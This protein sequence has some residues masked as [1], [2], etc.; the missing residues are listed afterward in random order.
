VP[1]TSDDS[2]TTARDGESSSQ[3]GQFIDEGLQQLLRVIN[4]NTVSIT[5]LEITEPPANIRRPSPLHSSHSDV[6]G[7]ATRLSPSVFRPNVKSAVRSSTQRWFECDDRGSQSS[8][9][10]DC[11]SSVV[12]KLIVENETIQ[13]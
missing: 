4:N 13:Q 11:G 7:D 1:H 5:S 12:S 6:E 2:S 8:D 10:M 3:L 9:V